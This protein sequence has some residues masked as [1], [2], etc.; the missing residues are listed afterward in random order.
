MSNITGLHHITALTSDAQQ[1]LDFYAGILGL[2]FVKK[3]VNYDA[4]DVYH[5]YYGNE[6]GDPGTVL[7]F[8][9]FPR[10]SQGKKGNGQA[11][12]TSFSV[13]ENALGYW[14]KRLR[15]FGIRFTGPQDRFEETYIYFEDFDGLGLE[16]VAFAGDNR[17]GFKDGHIPGEYS[18]KGF[19]SVLLSEDNYNKT[20]SLLT[21]QMDH[22]LVAEEGNRFRLSAGNENR[23]YTDIQFSPGTAEGYGGSGTIHHVAFAA[24]D[25]ESQLKFREKLLIDGTI[26]PTPVIDRQY[27]KSVYFR[28]PGGILF[29]AAT[30][31]PGFTID[32][33]VEHLGEKLCLPAWEEKNRDRIEKRL[34]QINFNADEFTDARLQY[35]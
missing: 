6:K 1:N 5:L 18:I 17:E 30:V 21:N 14:M 19:H 4:P 35:R 31:L 11:T 27:F 34:P 20:A 26:G 9:P 3:T 2:R 10:M 16:L 29:E 15:K 28:E 33:P 24:K 13:A 25:D 8:F 7:T 12:I 32:E 23:G 22:I